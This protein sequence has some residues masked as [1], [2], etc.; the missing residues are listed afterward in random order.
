MKVLLTGP[1]G[2]IG[3]ELARA[4]AASHEVVAV[5]PIEMDLTDAAAIRQTVRSVKPEVIVNAAGFTNVDQAESEPD[6]AF[7]VNGAA[8]SVLGAEAA[9][10]GAGVAHFSTDYVFDG[11]KTEPYRPDDKPNPLSLY[12][13]SKLAGE[14]ALAA[15]G[16][17]HLIIRTSWVY[18]ARR[19]NF[20][21]TILHQASIK[22]QLRIVDDQEGCPT[23]CRP[24]AD[25]VA[26]IIDASLKNGRQGTSFGAY[27]GTYHLAGAGATTWF[28]F[29]R[30][31]L[32]M[33]Q[34]RP[35]PELVPIC[36]DEFAAQAR[37][38]PYSVLDCSKTA[39]TFNVSLPPWEASLQ[40]FFDTERAMLPQREYAASGD[41]P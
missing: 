4:L 16:A 37:R 6:L 11:T 28:E 22:P 12:G 36:T 34:L 14:Q 20:L 24:L 41:S 30:R 35:A 1:D 40:E 3:W 8:V 19:H 32:E 27:Q 31:I 9:R 33:A 21:R 15:S 10:I 25:A 39:E 5:R 13:R 38:P 2:Q 17:S 23:W 29:A 18:G 26:R 7:A